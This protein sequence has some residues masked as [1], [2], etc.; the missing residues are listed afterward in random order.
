MILDGS[1]V[2][3]HCR[4][5]FDRNIHPTKGEWGH[6]CGRYDARSGGGEINFLEHIDAQKKQYIVL[7]NH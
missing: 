5:N 3:R 4:S 2:S 7:Q 1:H 6:R